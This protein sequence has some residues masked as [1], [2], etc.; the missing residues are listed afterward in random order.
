[1]KIEEASRIVRFK[2]YVA[3]DGTEFDTS[4]ECIKYELSVRNLTKIYVV[5]ELHPVNRS[6]IDL[7]FIAAFSTKGKAQSWINDRL[8]VIGL[9]QRSRFIIKSVFIDEFYEETT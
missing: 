4:E 7:R 8:D 1:M 9:H 2:I 3:E 5:N 6:G